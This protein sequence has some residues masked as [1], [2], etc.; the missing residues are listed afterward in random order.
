MLVTVVDLAAL[1]HEISVA[2][3]CSTNMR[4]LLVRLA[5]GIHRHI[6]VAEVEC[7][8]L[9]PN[10]REVRISAYAPGIAR[11]WDGTRSSRFFEQ[12]GVIAPVLVRDDLARVA[13]APVAL[14]LKLPVGRGGV[15]GIAW[16]TDI[17][18]ELGPKN[19]EML[20]DVLTLQ[21][22]RLGQLEA[23]ARRCRLANS[24]RKPTTENPVNAT[25]PPRP[26]PKQ[27]TEIPVNQVT[28]IPVESIDT[29]LVR[30]I[31]GALLQ[32]QGKIYGDDGAAAVLGLKPSTLQSK[33]RKLGIDRSRFLPGVRQA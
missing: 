18:V 14:K 23:T 25:P 22:L 19:T 1:L 3:G 16:E 27:S 11:R 21:C 12:Q 2:F 30:C 4:T 6:A 13:I 5:D 17:S 20:V 26:A 32:T 8:R 15:L 9:L 10:R 29:A 31:S 7:I 28:E 24:R 33:M